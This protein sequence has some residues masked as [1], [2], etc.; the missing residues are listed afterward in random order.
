MEPFDVVIVG[1]RCAGSP[2]AVLLARRSLRVCVLDKARFPSDTPS[3]HVIQPSGVAVLDRLGV[4]DTVLAAG[5]VQLTAFTMVNEH[6]RI[7]ADL[8]DAAVRAAYGA[9]GAGLCVRRVTLDHLLVA[10]AGEAGVDVRTRTGVT[11]LRH[12]GTRVTGVETT[13]G[14]VRASLVVG[15]DGRHSTVARLAGAAEYHTT[16]PC[17]P[18]TW[19]YFDGVADTEARLRLGRLG[20]LAFLSSPTDGGLY[21]AG[22]IPSSG[23][24][25]REES[26]MARFAAWP[27]LAERLDGARR[28]GPIRVV[29]DC[30]G[31]FRSATGPGWVLTGDAGQ[32]KDPTPAQG[33]S[34]AFRQA[35]RLADA[36]VAGLGGSAV[37]D[38]ELRRWW[39]WRDDDC[40][41]MH[42]LATDM[43]APGL[44]SPLITQVLRDIAGDVPAT[45]AL[46]RVL[47]RD[48]RPSRLFTPR[49]L[50]TA[51]ARAMGAQP[52]RI[53]ALAHEAASLAGQ[54][55]R[56]AR[57][58]RL[59]T[60]GR[61]LASVPRTRVRT[62][63]P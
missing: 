22:A 18:F 49:R 11:G 38:D 34:D 59:G 29:P 46:L 37:L 41:E 14:P 39:R 13:H 20:D 51:A 10:A 30:R 62:L 17:R 4:L 16:G 15:A 9:A 6:A 5:A 56:R 26:F 23:V 21:L 28:V 2:L 61:I 63:A 36:I 55:L 40:Y 44:P 45:V 24:D 43:G 35:E 12:D 1:A 7:E 57:Q 19:A 50:L 27:E 52:T 48:L 53:P 58:R 33:I 32:F 31:Y 8:T 42:W 60:R 47:N 3:T 54:E 25:T